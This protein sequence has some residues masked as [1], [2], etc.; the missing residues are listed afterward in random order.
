MANRQYVISNTDRADA[1]AFSVPGDE[2]GGENDDSFPLRN[3]AA[4]QSV[5]SYVHIENGWD[6][7]IDVTL[8]G[9]HFQDE[10]MS[11]A[12]DDGSAITVTS[13]GGTDF[14]DITSSHSFI[15][16]NVDPAADP[17]SGDLTITFQSREA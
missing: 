14:F 10:S 13:S 7:D 9:S 4:S 16:V 15:E 3:E 12:A 8:R 6:T 5:D 2:D 1:N 17:T 11:S